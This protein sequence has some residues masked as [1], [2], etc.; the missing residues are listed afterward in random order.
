MR[1]T[2]NASFDDC[3]DRLRSVRN[4]TQAGT[5]AQAMPFSRLA[6][7][8][9]SSVVPVYTKC[10]WFTDYNG[11]RYQKCWEVQDYYAPP[12]YAPRQRYY[13]GGGYGYGGGG[14]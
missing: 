6:D 14:Y 7:H 5:S 4:G 11:Y 13:G 3:G 8:T 12:V 2:Y 9:T 10:R 1:R